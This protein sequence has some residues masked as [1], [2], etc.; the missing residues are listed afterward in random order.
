MAEE[1]EDRAVPFIR[2]GFGREVNHSPIEALEVSGRD[3][4]FY[5]EFLNGIRNRKKCHLSRFRL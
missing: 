4:C 2:G 5:L 3:I 1:L